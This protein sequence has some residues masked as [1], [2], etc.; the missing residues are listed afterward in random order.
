VCAGTLDDLSWFVPTSH[1]W[2]EQANEAITF[3]PDALLVV[4]QPQTRQILFDA[5]DRAYPKA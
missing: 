3:A 5:F 1:I 4:G 2:V